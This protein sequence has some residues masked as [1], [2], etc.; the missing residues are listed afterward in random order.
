MHAW[1][2][3]DFLTSQVVLSALQ[4]PRGRTRFPRVVSN[5]SFAAFILRGGTGD[6]NGKCWG[7]SDAG[8]GT[9]GAAAER[10]GGAS[11]RPAAWGG[12]WPACDPGHLAHFGLELSM[13]SPG[14]SPGERLKTDV[15][16]REIRMGRGIV[17]RTLVVYLAFCAI[18]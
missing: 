15:I 11:L 1:F 13:V 14:M 2:P 3:R 18:G 8:H 5:Y 9:I 17:S 12:R 7:K 10:S 16:V 4:A 6:F